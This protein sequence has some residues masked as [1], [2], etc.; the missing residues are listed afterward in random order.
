M[1]PF[2]T[3]LDVANEVMRRRPDL[4]AGEVY[5]T[6]EWH[7]ART[8]LVKAEQSRSVGC[9]VFV[10]RNGHKVPG[11]LHTFHGKIIGLDGHTINVEFHSEIGKHIER[12]YS[13]EAYFYICEQGE[14]YAPAAIRQKLL[15]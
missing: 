8:V 1:S 12:F 15:G 9:R 6:A 14:Q 11:R 4:P 3:P 13:H 2:V 5:S 7:A 10:R